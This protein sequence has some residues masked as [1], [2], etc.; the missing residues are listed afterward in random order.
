MP[1]RVCLQGIQFLKTLTDNQM[2][3]LVRTNSLTDKTGYFGHVY[4]NGASLADAMLQAGYCFS[5]PV[6]NKKMGPQKG[7]IG[8]GPGGGNLDGYPDPSFVGPGPS[9]MGGSMFSGDR[10]V[11]GKGP[12]RDQRNTVSPLGNHHPNMG[13]LGMGPPHMNQHHQPNMG[14][15][16]SIG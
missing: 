9:L 7:P 4:V 6:M 12:H 3:Q 2:A 1:P 11:A 13:G 8:L 14:F 5:K 15:P 16:M 10:Q